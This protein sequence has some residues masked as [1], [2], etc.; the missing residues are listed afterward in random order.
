MVVL[1]LPALLATATVGPVLGN[2]EV[3]LHA[4]ITT[5]IE[6]S[7]PPGGRGR[8]LGS[9]LAMTPP[10]S[11]CWAVTSNYTFLQPPFGQCRWASD[12]L[13]S[14]LIVSD[15]LLFK[16]RNKV[17]AAGLVG[18]LELWLAIE[19]AEPQRRARMPQL[20]PEKRPAAPLETVQHSVSAG[21]EQL[22]Q[23]VS[24]SPRSPVR[25]PKNRLRTESLKL[26]VL[27]L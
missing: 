3:T 23:S 20:A 22:L 13:I 21:N 4:A 1:L 17:P 25:S 26:Q 7:V 6:E 27:N 19:P 18:L 14:D 15:I 11:T 24:N 9:S 10:R 5:A 8:G 2:L 12:L 16:T